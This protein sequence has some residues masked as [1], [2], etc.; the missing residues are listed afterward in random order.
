MRS[1]IHKASAM[2]KGV[3]KKILFKEEENMEDEFDK[4]ASPGEISW[5]MILHL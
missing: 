5:I 4:I 3:K 1:K 2:N